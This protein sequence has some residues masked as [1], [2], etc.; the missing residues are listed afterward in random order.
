MQSDHKHHAISAVGTG[1]AVPAADQALLT[2][3]CK[4]ITIAAQLN[5]YYDHCAKHNYYS[6]VDQALLLWIC[7]CIQGITAAIQQKRPQTSMPRHTGARHHQQRCR[8]SHD[9]LPAMALTCAA[10]HC[11]WSS[12]CAQP[13]VSAC[14]PHQPQRHGRPPT[15]STSP[16]GTDRHRGCAA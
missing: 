3:L 16:S 5:R 1:V 10:A 12:P 15:A 8:R 7:K 14:N 4:Y 9:H 11:N 6:T 2:L 13:H